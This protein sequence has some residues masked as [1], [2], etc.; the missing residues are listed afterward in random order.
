MPLITHWMTW[1]DFYTV[2]TFS[3]FGVD[4]TFNVSNFDLTVTTYD[5]LLLENQQ[6]PPGKSPTMIDPMFIH[7]R[8]DFLLTIF[9]LYYN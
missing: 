6:N 5:Y 4:S 8:K 9:T 1:Y 3:D 2:P 7:V